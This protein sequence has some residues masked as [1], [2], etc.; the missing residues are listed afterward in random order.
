MKRHTVNGYQILKSAD[1]YSRVA[2]Y[3]LT[4]HERWDGKGYP[5]HL[6]GEEIP[7]YS[8][9]IAVC[10][11]YEAMTSKRVY[12]TALSQEQAISELQRSARAQFDPLIVDIFVE[13][14]LK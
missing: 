13:K 5:N 1:K 11:A 7:L 12:K 4:H 3:A 8:R 2:E 9:I 10:D 14:V 6:K